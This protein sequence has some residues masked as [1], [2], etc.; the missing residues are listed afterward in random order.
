LAVLVRLYW[1]QYVALAILTILLW[2]SEGLTPYHHVLYSASDNELWKYSYPLR[3]NQVPAWAVPAISILSPL[4][5]IAVAF[6]TG[7]ISLLEAHQAALAAT[8][9]VVTTGLTTNFIK[10]HVGRFRPNFMAR[11]WP[12]GGA[13]QF[14]P[15]GRPQ[16]TDDAVDPG[17]GMK[18]FPSGETFC[19]NVSPVCVCSI[20]Y[21][22]QLVTLL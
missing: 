7:H 14:A 13:P 10:I 15:D 21:H 12:D 8:T 18:S 5:A 2:I 4:F 22:D 16:C 3:V 20:W 9:C 17:E 19:L 11:C 1:R 6:L